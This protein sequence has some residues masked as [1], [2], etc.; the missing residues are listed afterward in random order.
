MTGRLFS[1]TC[2]Y[3]SF[4]L[5]VIA[6][7]TGLVVR[8]VRL[9]P[10]ANR[11]VPVNK[12]WCGTADTPSYFEWFIHRKYLSKKP[13]KTLL[14][15][16]WLA[17]SVCAQT[18]GEFHTSSEVFGFLKMWRYLTNSAQYTLSDIGSQVC[19]VV[20]QILQPR[21]D[22]ATSLL[23]PCASA[24]LDRFTGIS[25]L[26]PFCSIS[27]FSQNKFDALMTFISG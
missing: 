9:W 2:S 6:E 23:R 27:A 22:R 16:S 8:R 17:I 25:P 13:N 7:G 3:L 10:A 5:A 12:P 18:P 21:C 19:H 15:S 26:A 24:N 20:I 1:N 4:R 14:L 11:T